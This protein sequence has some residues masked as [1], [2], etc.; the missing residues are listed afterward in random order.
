[1]QAIAET[2]R[3]VQAAEGDRKRVWNLL[4]PST[5]DWF[6]IFLV[7]W[8]FVLVEPG[9]NRLLDDG[10]TGWHIR[11][12]EM[13][14]S[15]GSVPTTDPFSFSKPKAEWFAWEWLSEVVLAELHGWLGLKGVVW[16]A[17]VLIAAF[18]VLLLRYTLWLG[19]DPL[20]ALLTTLLAVGAASVHYLAR[21][22]L[23]TMLLLVVSLWIIGRDLRRPGRAVWA[24]VPMAALWANLHGG[25]L[26]LLFCLGSVGGVAFLEAALRRSERRTRLAQGGRYA[27]LTAACAAA[28]LVNPYGW[29]LHRHILS[30]LSSD[31]IKMSIAEFQSPSFRA[32]NVLQ[33]EIL[34]ISGLLV[35][36]RLLWERRYVDALWI[37]AWAHFS[38][39]SAR[40]IPMY[41]IFAAP[42][43]AVEG[44]K[45]WRAWALGQP[46]KSPGRTLYEFGRDLGAGL[47]R[48]TLWS[49]VFALSLLAVP[50]LLKWP[51]DFPESEFPLAVI[52]RNEN[53]IRGRRVFTDDGWADYLLYRFFPVQRVFMDGR[54]DFYG[55]E[56]GEQYLDLMYGRPR[57]RELLRKYEFEAVL[58]PP[59]RPLAALLDLD[60]DWERCD[61]DEDAVLFVPRAEGPNPGPG[62]AHPAQARLG[63]GILVPEANETVPPGRK[64]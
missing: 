24:L 64:Y 50:G 12:G 33:F 47:G 45:A 60:P 32:E 63:T 3:P 10:D 27:A 31:W 43:V 14:L 4:V 57:W 44:S 11:V 59:K 53:L 56:I 13:I 28:T 37:A 38:L 36:G 7:L 49:A 2:R 48:A 54:S 20:V 30:Y 52:G 15:S 58:V 6:F 55:E 16:F 51:S 19:A 5:L 35:A 62:G 34:L 46:R 9:W 39:Q 25:F 22:H 8:L 61:E 23:F 21:P 17:G 29:E 18:A 42:L 41:A 40:H 26:V 1:M